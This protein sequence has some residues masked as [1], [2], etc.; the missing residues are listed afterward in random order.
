MQGTNLLQVQPLATQPFFLIIQKEI[1]KEINKTFGPT[2]FFEMWF[3]ESPI[4]M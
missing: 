1:T 4:M 2:N 3:I